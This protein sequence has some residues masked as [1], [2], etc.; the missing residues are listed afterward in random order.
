M[1]PRILAMTVMVVGALGLTA[2]GRTPGERALSGGLI[3]AGAGA[4]VGAIAGGD[5]L[6]AALIGGG[7]G[8]VAGAVTAPPRVGYAGPP[9]GHLRGRRVGHYR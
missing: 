5:P 9:P 1:H 4:G 3:G 6:T 8:A 2:C 7:V